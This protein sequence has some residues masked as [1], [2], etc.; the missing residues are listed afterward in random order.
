MAAKKQWKPW[1][2]DDFADVYDSGGSNF[3]ETFLKAQDT[4]DKRRYNDMLMEERMLDLE[5][6]RSKRRGQ[7]ALA[8]ALATS[9]GTNDRGALRRGLAQMGDIDSLLKLEQFDSTGRERERDRE[10][11]ELA[12]VEKFAAFSPEL[13]LQL[14]NQGSL[15]R[16]YGLKQDPGIFKKREPLKASGGIFYRDDGDDLEI[17]RDMRRDPIERPLRPSW[18]SVYDTESGK[19]RKVNA[20][21]PI[22]QD[23]FEDGTYLD[24]SE[25]PKDDPFDL[26]PKAE[27]PSGPGFFS[28]FWDG[29]TGSTPQAAPAPM[30]SPV[31][32]ASPT[33]EPRVMIRRKP[34]GLVSR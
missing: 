11:K 23:R 15:G 1:E 31:P 2:D 21:D 19:V 28:S 3:V 25:A 13:A 4:F 9:D 8:Q 24:K 18:Q 10:D 27:A 30:V 14:W 5:D 29:I 22:T 16:R 6:R 12:T 20:N 7:S 32:M 33:P 17:V 26:E 34:S